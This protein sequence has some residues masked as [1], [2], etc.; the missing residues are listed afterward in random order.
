[1][2]GTI[3]SDEVARWAL[4]TGEWL[5]GTA[6][7]AF[8]E[9]QTS[10]Q[11]VVDAV[12]GMVPLLGD[13]T[14]V[15]DLLAV[16]TR[17]A[18]NPQKREEVMEWV[19]LVILLFAL[20]PV[21]GGV[22]KGVGRLLLKAGK[23]AAENH[24]ALEEVVDFLNRMGHGN[25][26]K[27]IKELDLLKYQ[28]ELIQKFSAFCD[29]IVE[30]MRTMQ[31]RLGRVLSQDMKDLMALWA[32]RFSQLKSLGNKMIPQALK[33][34]NTKLKAVQQAIYKGEIHSVMPGMKNTTREEEARLV[35]DAA[36]LPKSARNGFKANTIADYHH[37]DGWP[38]LS[39]NAQEQKGLPDKYPDIEAFSG[40]LKDV[41]L[42]P[43][44]KIYRVI[45][46]DKNGKARPWWTRE[47]PS[48]AQVW[49]E[50]AAVLDNFNHN[51]HYIEF[52]IP[53]GAALKA[54]EGKAAEQLNA[55]TG[56]YLPGGGVQ[57]FV[58]LPSDIAA[59][60]NKLTPKL[61]GWGETLKLYGFEYSRSAANFARTERLGSNE[62]QAK[63]ATEKAD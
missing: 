51:G 37:K 63:N 8:N 19:L 46:I 41:T 16:S 48:N 26:I 34:L 4:E 55:A 31:N 23:T 45:H 57:L 18:E 10:S 44:E 9:K 5:W 49:R 14:A 30:T 21:V 1:M 29:K 61:T 58:E 50:Q 20:I 60:M 39:K 22:I 17:M 12:I 32:T 6:Q 53:E 24:K 38:D 2:S 59:A 13:A 42:K 25:A 33:E 28:A 15:R 62:I 11:I 40:S 7:G 36:P 27:F 56:Q 43:G 35:E 47:L 3:S 52:V 54:W